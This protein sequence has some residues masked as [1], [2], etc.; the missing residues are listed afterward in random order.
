VTDGSTDVATDVATEDGT[1]GGDVAAGD[2]DLGFELYLANCAQCHGAQDSAQGPS[3]SNMS[4]AAQTRVSGMAAVTG[5]VQSIVDPG[6]FVV[7][8]YSN[9][10]PAGFGT[11]FSAQE[12]NSLA[13]FIL[14]F[15]PAS[16]M[17]GAAA[18]SDGQ[19][20]SEQETGGQ[21]TAGQATGSQDGAPPVLPSEEVLTV[22]GRLVQGTAGG[23]AI[24]PGLAVEL[25][26]LDAHGN[27]AGTYDT[28][29]T[30]ENTFTFENVARAAGNMYLIQVDYS[31]V[32]Q[33]AQISPLQGDEEEVSQDDA[34]RAHQRYVRRHDPWAQML[35]NSRRLRNSGWRAAGTGQQW[36]PDHRRRNGW[37]EDWFVSSTLEL[38]V[39]SFGIQPM[40]SETSQ[41]YVVEVVDNIPM[42]KDTWPL[43]PGQV[44]TITVA[45]YL[46]YQDGAVI[47][48]AFGYPVIDGT[49]L[50]PNDTVQFA[51]D[52]F[53]LGGEWRYRVSEGGVR[54]T[55]LQPD[56][57]INPDKDFTLVKAHDLLTPTRP[58]DRI[59]FELAG[60]PTRTLD[61]MSASPSVVSAD[62]D[63]SNMLPVIMAA[64]GLAIILM[65][66]VL[67]WRQRGVVQVPAR[68]D[69][70]AAG[71]IRGQRGAAQGDCPAGRRLRGWARGR[72]HLRGTARNP[73]RP[74]AAAAGRGGMILLLMTD[75]TE[76]WLALE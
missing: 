68:P 59:V 57:S 54:V 1:E 28:V 70:D 74:A 48:Q 23:A 10:M 47:D 61:V 4:D 34:V 13:K 75:D 7:E 55:E 9:I 25:Y 69:V 8:G 56:E 32:P 62:E 3:L 24:P 26:A 31:D 22:T 41:R 18:S 17:G 39:G 36:E 33:G 19:E 11:Q 72:R 42:V 27:L 65:G 49:V 6:A 16:M 15:D 43:R 45:Y 66:G 44:Q 67:W 50:V 46:P 52:Q 58:D 60:R 71:P 37:A 64:A 21:E 53:D 14:E 2:Y 30:E 73:D 40:Q 76:K 63:D 20:T 38:P 51:S 35:I 5:V 29:S 12:I